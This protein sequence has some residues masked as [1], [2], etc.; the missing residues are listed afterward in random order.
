MLLYQGFDVYFGCLH[1]RLMTGPAGF[2]SAYKSQKW[3]IDFITLADDV[4][5]VSDNESYD[6]MGDSF[7]KTLQLGLNIAFYKTHEVR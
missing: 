6:M 1:T 3:A 7:R 2:V 4:F 5:H